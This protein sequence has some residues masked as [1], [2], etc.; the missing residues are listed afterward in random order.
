MSNTS[1]LASTGCPATLTFTN[2]LPGGDKHPGCFPLLIATS[3]R[4]LSIAEE[5]FGVKIPNYAP[6]HILQFFLASL[7][8]KI[9]EKGQIN[10]CSED[11]SVF[12][13][14]KFEFENSPTIVIESTSML[15][16]RQTPTVETP[17]VFPN[18][19]ESPMELTK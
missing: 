12:D 9:V 6:G 7:L 5:P 19:F 15:Q 11:K 17:S 2:S 4:A 1:N 18:V 16:Q 8:R 14:N 13:A 10:N 3:E